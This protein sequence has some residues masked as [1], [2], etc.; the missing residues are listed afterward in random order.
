MSNPI[1]L[2]QHYA[3]IVTDM[4]GLGRSAE[5]L[6]AFRHSVVEAIETGEVVGGDVAPDRDTLLANWHTERMARWA[7]R[8]RMRLVTDLVDGGV[9]QAFGY[10]AQFDVPIR[11]CDAATLTRYT[12]TKYEQD[13]TTMYSL[14]RSEDLRLIAMYLHT[15]RTN[16]DDLDDKAQPVLLH[17]ADLAAPY[18]TIPS[19]YLAGALIGVGPFV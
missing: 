12:G 5:Q 13:H 15:K 9:Q 11:V 1:T 2:E 3:R 16:L 19:A 6:Q 14:L 4:P 18:K 17:V 7:G 8:N 10:G